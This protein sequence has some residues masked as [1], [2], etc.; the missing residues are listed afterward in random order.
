MVASAP[1]TKSP[2]ELLASLPEAQR[3]AI[4]E[5]LT[6][7]QS[8]ALAYDWK[9]WG[10][11]NQQP[12]DGDWFGWL[13]LAGRGYGKT[14]TGSEWIR[15]EVQRGKAG[16]IA[17]VGETAADCRDVIVEG[18][19]LDLE[20]PVP[21]PDGWTTMGA[22]RPGDRVFDEHGQ[23]CNVVWVSAVAENRTCYEVRFSDGE[24]IVADAAHKWLTR[25]AR[26]R[27]AARRSANPEDV[28]AVRTTGEIG[29]TLVARGRANHAIPLPGA[30]AYPESHLPIDPYV[31]GCWLGDGR[32]R[33]GDPTCADD[34]IVE[35]IEAAGYRVTR[36]ATEYGWRIDG[37]DPALRPLGVLGNKHIPA[38]Y[39]RGSVDQRLAL[40][41]GLMDTG[42][43]VGER[44]RCAY[45]GDDAIL[46]EQVRELVRGLGMSCGPM[47]APQAHKAFA[48]AAPVRRITFTPTLP[49]CRLSRKAARIRPPSEE[50]SWRMVR[51]VRPVASV[52]VRCIAVDSAS[53][54]FLAG[55]GCVPTHNSG[56]LATSPPWFK[57][58]YEPANRR[59]TWP[60]GAYAICFS[61]EK[62]DQLRG[63]NFD[64]AWV[65][66]IAKFRHAQDTWDNLELGLRSGD[67]PKVCITTTPRPI[68]ILRGFLNDDMI[69]VVTGSSYENVGNLA[70][71]FIKR[72]LSKY[73]GTRLGRQELHAQILDDNPGALWRYELFEAPCR[74]RAEDVP[75]M[76]QIVV[77]IDPAVSSD[78]DSDDTAII[79]AGVGTDGDLY[80]LEDLSCHETPDVW[81]KS[82]VDAF[83]RW[84]ANMIIGEANNG[85]DLIEALL[86]T[87]DP[88]IPYEKIIASRGKYVRAEPIA[89]LYE[90]RRVHHVGMFATMEDEMVNWTPGQADSPDRLDG[91]VWAGTYLMLQPIQPKTIVRP[92]FIGVKRR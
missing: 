41:Q 86:R 73:E 76:V 7:P 50:A 80:I 27:N 53:H 18:E 45:D 10:R 48:G 57:P 54:L 42:G 46:V 85:G 75:P 25:D 72:V 84:E 47:S 59:V 88:F 17:L 35:Q 22:L 4:L 70:P 82:A 9:F 38:I 13:I 16:R 36:H 71:S 89:A 29:A 3:Q 12:P 58:V 19:A 15:D 60:N 24:T 44:G 14:R 39:L 67:D 61:S 49:V 37:I 23:P 21:T 77:A 1:A 91:V 43:Y 26:A 65:D 20:T 79:V 51:A 68:P 74:V 52:P 92:R 30:L 40:L 90:Q 81:A 11:P 56:I 64:R 31:F 83:H 5:E 6:E 28:P 63:L 33:G 8:R 32:S 78:E 62:P 66:E 55:H 2:A 34:E 69:R 87:I